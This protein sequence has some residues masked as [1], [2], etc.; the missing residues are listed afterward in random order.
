LNTLVED[1]ELRRLRAM[2]DG[3][4]P[5]VRA[6]LWEKLAALSVYKYNKLP[7]RERLG[8]GYYLAAQRRVES[9]KE[10]SPKGAQGV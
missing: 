3:S 9:L 8:L 6:G 5:F 4:K 10:P 2:A 1:D 7:P